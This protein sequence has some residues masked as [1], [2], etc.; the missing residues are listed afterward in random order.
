MAGKPEE[1]TQA[2]H[3]IANVIRYDDGRGDLASVDRGGRFGLLAPGGTAYQNIFSGSPI[4]DVAS[5]M[6]PGH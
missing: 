2:V 5:F 4:I 6:I 3:H 1:Y